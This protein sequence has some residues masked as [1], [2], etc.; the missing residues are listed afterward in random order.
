MALGEA[1]VGSAVEYGP[2]HEFGT[3]QIAAR[4]HWRVAVAEIIEEVGGKSG[5]S[6]E[7]FEAAFSDHNLMAVALKIERRVKQ[8]IT[9]KHI[10]DT[11]NYRGSVTSGSTDDEVFAKSASLAKDPRT[12]AG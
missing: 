12:V 4:E 1:W 8:I 6:D 7:I 9:E 5:P 10:L 2:Y 3:S 11:G